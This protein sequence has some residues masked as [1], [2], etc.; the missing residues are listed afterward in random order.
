[1]LSKNQL[2]EEYI[3]FL[4]NL[5]YNFNAEGEYLNGNNRK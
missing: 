5:F 2:K 4:F 3:C 1:M